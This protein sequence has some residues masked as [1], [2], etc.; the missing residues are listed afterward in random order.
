MNK[1]YSLHKPDT[2]P[3][4]RIALTE[5]SEKGKWMSVMQSTLRR[6]HDDR[7]FHWEV[8]SKK[9]AVNVLPITKENEIILIDQ[10]RYPIMDWELE[11]PAETMDVDED[12]PESAAVRA[13]TEEIGY[14]CE[15]LL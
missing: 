15:R 10:F 2:I 1:R 4:K 14:R 7:V 9:P 3:V 6:V 5:L 11:C 13:L 12:T 8:L